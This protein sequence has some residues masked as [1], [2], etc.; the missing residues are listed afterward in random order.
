MSRAHEERRYTD[1]E[2]ALVLRKATELRTDFPV[3]RR[4]GVG[5]TLGEMQ[6]IAAEAG[7]DPDLVARAAALLPAH[8]PSVAA[9]IFGGP[10]KYRMVRSVPG[11]IPAEE[12]A[13]FVE[14]IRDVLQQQ[15]EATQV[16]G[17]L[18]WKTTTDPT[19]VSVNVNPRPEETRLEVSVDRAGSGL[20]S[21]LGPLAAFAVATAALAVGLGVES[22]A[23]I[24]TAILSGLGA[25]FFAGRTIFSAGTRKWNE[26][27]PTL[28]DA[29]AGTAEKVAQREVTEGEAPFPPER[30]P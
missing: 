29:L 9:W 19:R 18:E 17:G 20:L 8:R 16:L 23:G 10:D 15:G 11:T 2:F 1:Q 24:L 22:A 4:E 14:T 3:A 27:V 30:E 13:R 7:I 21:Y 12:L 26:T 6:Q 5:L 25:A 28:M